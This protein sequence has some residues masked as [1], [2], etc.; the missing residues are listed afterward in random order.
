MPDCYIRHATAE[1]KPAVLVMVDH[2]L[3]ASAFGEILAG[4]DGGG[5]LFDLALSLGVIFVAQNTTTG[6]LDG[7]LAV[8]ALEHPILHRKYADELVWWVEPEARGRRTG[9]KL[10]DYMEGWARTEGLDMA[11]MVAPAGS[12]VGT[13]YR[14]RGYVAVETTFYKRL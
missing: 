12:N 9:I 2:F 6:Q 8:L 1:D 4:G 11:K 14:R 10:I 3:Q 5:T 7:M 13:F